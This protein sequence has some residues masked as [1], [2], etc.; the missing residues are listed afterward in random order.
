MPG[1]NVASSSGRGEEI[2]E[3]SIAGPALTGFGGLLAVA[4]TGTDSA[5]H[6]NL[7]YLPP[8]L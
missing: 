4:W 7:G 1:R 3:T 6:L 2:A 8:G 5:H